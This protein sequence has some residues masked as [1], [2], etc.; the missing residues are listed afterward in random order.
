M[1]ANG[2]TAFAARSS[3]RDMSSSSP[4]RAKAEL[5]SSNSAY[6]TPGII[7]IDSS[8]VYLDNSSRSPFS[9]SSMT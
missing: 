1:A 9:I 5:H 6:F 4:E 8:S 3:H 2:E 7:Y